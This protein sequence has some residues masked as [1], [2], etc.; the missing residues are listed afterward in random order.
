M[1]RHWHDFIRSEY[2]RW[3]VPTVGGLALICFAIL[4]LMGLSADKFLW[5][6]GTIVLSY[7]LGVWGATAPQENDDTTEETDIAG[8]KPKWVSIMQWVVLVVVF[9]LFVF[10]SPI[11][12]MLSGEENLTEGL[13]HCLWLAAAVAAVMV[14]IV[15]D[16]RKKKTNKI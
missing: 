16:T 3:C 15:L 2:W 13:R 14:P 4:Y 9:M 12:N 11:I 10:A 7:I 8:D 6:L 5:F 1:R